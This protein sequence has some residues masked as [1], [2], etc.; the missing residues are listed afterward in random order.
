MI[1]HHHHFLHMKPTHAG[2]R[3]FSVPAADA[4]HFINGYCLID[5]LIQNS[6]LHKNF[7]PCEQQ[8]GPTC[9]TYHNEWLEEPLEVDQS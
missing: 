6:A 8:K 4:R 2:V 9:Y 5:Y 1:H 3:F 7:F